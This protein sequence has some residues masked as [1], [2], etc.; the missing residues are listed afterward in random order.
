MCVCV[1]IGG[2]DPCTTAFLLPSAGWPTPAAAGCCCP[3]LQVKKAGFMK[4]TL[5]N[6]AFNRKLHALKAGHTWDKVRAPAPWAGRAGLKAG[7]G[8]G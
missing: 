6:W 4:R 7:G 2:T 1:V 8:E 3:L 5:F